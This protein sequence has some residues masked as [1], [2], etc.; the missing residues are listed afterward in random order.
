M[1]TV[2]E[3]L[4][5]RTYLCENSITPADISIFSCLRMVKEYFFIIKSQF[6]EKEWKNLVCLRRWMSNL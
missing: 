1:K 3:R 4:K 5:L 2:D 6:D